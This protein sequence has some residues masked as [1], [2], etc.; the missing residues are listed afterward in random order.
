MFMTCLNTVIGA[1]AQAWSWFF[2]LLDGMGGRGTFVTV[3]LGLFTINK[4]VDLVIMNFLYSP[5]ADGVGQVETRYRELSDPA[6]RKANNKARGK[7]G[8]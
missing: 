7:R 4:F 6:L 3:F 8:K 1:V 5:T 2:R